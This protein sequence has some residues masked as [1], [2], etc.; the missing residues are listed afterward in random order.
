[1]SE[2][3]LL[4]PQ[5]GEIA[6]VLTAG[7]LLAAAGIGPDS[8]IGDRAAFIDR[9]RELKRITSEAQ[10]IV[11]DD[12]IGEMDRNGRWTL[13][14]DGYEIKG[15]SPAAGAL[16]FD[17]ASLRVALA[18]LVTDGVISGMA[19]RAALEVA[20]PTAAVPY[21][22]LRGAL[23]ALDNEL[24]PEGVDDLRAVLEALVLAEPEPTYTPRLGHIKALL[25]IPAARRVIELCAIDVPAP[26]RTARVKRTR[27]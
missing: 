6:P 10:G 19:A 18:E 1:M 24:T 11:S 15:S 23:A 5:T 3:R 20:E 8:S 13:H 27:A 4:D 17:V 7:D 2:L 22:V 21:N 12:L 16:A 26:R 25:K 14:E 9:A